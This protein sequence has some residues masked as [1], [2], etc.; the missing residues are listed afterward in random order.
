[1]VLIVEV[2]I[3]TPAWR[4]AWPRVVA[5]TK[6]L[7]RVALA[8]SGGKRSQL[9]PS[10]KIRRTGKPGHGELNFEATVVLADD[11][12]LKDLNARF[13]RKDKPTNVLSFPDGDNPPGG[14]IAL[15]LETISAE[16]EAQGKSFVNHAKHM[17]LHGFLH[18]RGYDHDRPRAARL[19]EGLE[20]AILARMG[21]PNP[22]LIETKTRA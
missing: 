19:M 12:R 8:D 21:I 4:K 3:E 14:G 1:M 10:S 2:Q 15:S 16:A 20:I 5:E 17:I 7:L 22:Y 9:P 13:R 11:A 6:E 18:L